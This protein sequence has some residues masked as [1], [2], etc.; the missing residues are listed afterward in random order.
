MYINYHQDDLKTSEEIENEQN[1]GDNIAEDEIYV[2]EN[3]IH[4]DDNNEGNNDPEESEEDD[5]ASG[6]HDAYHG[7]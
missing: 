3:G 1:N 4:Y 2:E 6:H 5:V 7:M